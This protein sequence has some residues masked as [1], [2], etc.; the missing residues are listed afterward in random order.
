LT[1]GKGLLL[2]S[3]TSKMIDDD[4]VKPEPFKKIVSGVEEMKARLATA[5]A[6]IGSDSEVTLPDPS[7]TACSES[8]TLTAPHPMSR[9]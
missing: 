1:F 8:D 9:Y 6:S 2:A 3:R 4:S 5:G 7:M